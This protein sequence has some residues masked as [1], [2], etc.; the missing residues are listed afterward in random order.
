VVRPG[1]PIAVLR[2]LVGLNQLLGGAIG[3]YVS[4]P[5]YLRVARFIPVVNQGFILLGIALF[6]LAVLSGLLLIDGR[7]QSLAMSMWVQ[8]L[9]IVAIQTPFVL[10]QYLVGLYA[11]ISTQATRLGALNLTFGAGFDAAVTIGPANNV[12]SF[13]VTLNFIA[14]LSLVFLIWLRLRRPRSDEATP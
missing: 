11:V 1:W 7:R 2:W 10:Y 6:T 13:V 12:T 5:E 3:L 8:A 14:V 9:Q 4:V